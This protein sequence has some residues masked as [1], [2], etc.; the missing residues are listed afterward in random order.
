MTHKTPK[1]HKPSGK[2]EQDFATLADRWVDQNWYLPPGGDQS[3]REREARRLFGNGE[4]PINDKEGAPSAEQIDPQTDEAGGSYQPGFKRAGML[5]I[6]LPVL[7][8]TCAMLIIVPILMPQIL[9]PGFWDT[10]EPRML[11][12][13]PVRMTNE[14]AVA[15][16]VKLRSTYESGSARDAVASQALPQQV[17]HAVA[18]TKA[19]LPLPRPVMSA[20]VKH[21]RQQVTLAAPVVKA[22]PPKASSPGK[23]AAKSL[24]PI[25]AEYFASRAAAAAKEKQVA[26]SSRPIGQAY[27]ES[28]SPATTD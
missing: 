15:E 18:P 20:A 8:A 4:E 7:L 5:N 25:G 21:D 28:H 19:A 17:E 13:M 10:R 16:N 24:P 1:A 2:P 26:D 6:V 11:S 3:W 12:D 27:F 22:Q 9:T 23:R 14:A